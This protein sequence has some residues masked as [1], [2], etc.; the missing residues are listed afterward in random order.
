MG[1]L[2]LAVLLVAAVWLAG[3]SLDKRGVVVVTRESSKVT[4]VMRTADGFTSPDGVLLRDGVLYFADEGGSAVRMWSQ[5]GGMQTLADGRAGLQSP[6]D[7]V[8]DSGGRIFFTDDAAGAV[9]VIDADRNVRLLAGK[10]AG[11]V[12]PEGIV[13]APDGAL[14]VGDGGCH[15]IFRITTDGEISTFLGCDYGIRKPESM[16]FDD[17]GNLYIAD[18]DDGVLYLLDRDRKLHRCIAS[19][20]DFSPES[21]CFFRGALYITDSQAGKLYCLGPHEELETLAIFE[22]ELLG[23]QGVAPHPEGGVLLT[24]QAAGNTGFLLRISL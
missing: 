2:I 5:G 16:A 21:I 12:S 15:R 17:E 20:E 24:V 7:L 9:W 10:E 18:N 4:V 6:E 19:R 23:V 14:L 22:G 3:R 11:L 8:V 1:K 13:L